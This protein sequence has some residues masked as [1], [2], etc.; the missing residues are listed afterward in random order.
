MTPLAHAI[1][2]AIDGGQHK[3]P[4]VPEERVYEVDAE[5]RRQLGIDHDSAL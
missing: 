1:K 2:R 4:A 5:L 3:L